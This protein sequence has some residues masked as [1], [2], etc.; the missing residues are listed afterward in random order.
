LKTSK[1]LEFE[2]LLPTKKSDGLALNAAAP[3]ASTGNIVIAVE[4]NQK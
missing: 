4:K 2:S 1:G 3:F